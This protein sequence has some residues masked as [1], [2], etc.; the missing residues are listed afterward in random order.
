MQVHYLVVATEQA[1][2]VLLLRLPAGETA[3]ITADQYEQIT[4]EQMGEFSTE[5]KL[6]LRQ[7]ATECGCDLRSEHDRVLFTKNQ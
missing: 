4:G 3:Y 7:I 5:G 2:R 6:M 1:L